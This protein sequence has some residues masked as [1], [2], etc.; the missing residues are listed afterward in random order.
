MQ[1]IA[2]NWQTAEITVHC[3]FQTTI[4][5]CQLLT[6]TDSDL[7]DVLNSDVTYKETLA[8]EC[9]TLCLHF[10]ITAFR[11]PKQHVT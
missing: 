10:V 7:C 8:V 4:G 9:L 3:S 1:Y 11:M 6:S 5:S 2:L